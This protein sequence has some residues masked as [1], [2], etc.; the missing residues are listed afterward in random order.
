MAAQQTPNIQSAALAF[1]N[2]YYQLYRTDRS[3]LF[4]LYQK[5]ALLSFEGTVF[6]GAETIGKKYSSLQFK[7]V[8][9]K[10][11]SFD[12]LPSGANNGILVFVCG[13]L[14]VDDDQNAVKFSQVF[15]MYPSD[16]SL[17]NFIIYNDMFRLN[18]G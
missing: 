3:K 2:Q 7:K 16:P 11:L 18:Y 13:D 14:K 17:K 4:L 5:E 9:H 12:C 8:A 6:Q 1:I 10:M 15:H